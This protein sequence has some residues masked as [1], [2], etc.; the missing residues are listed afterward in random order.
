MIAMKKEKERVMVFVGVDDT[1]QE[2][3]FEDDPSKNIL[4][5]LPHRFPPN[6]NEDSPLAK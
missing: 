3:L 4:V 1:N 6:C 5:D 2:I